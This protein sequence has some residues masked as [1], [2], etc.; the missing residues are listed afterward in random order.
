MDSES[1]PFSVHQMFS[2]GFSSFAFQSHLS[3]LIFFFTPCSPDSWDCTLM[4]TAFCDIRNESEDEYSELEEANGVWNK[5][6]T[7][8]VLFI[9]AIFYGGLVTFI[10]V[11][12][13]SI[14]SIEID[15]CH[16]FVSQLPVQ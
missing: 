2:I 15:Y 10:K 14:Q 7:F 12:R 5:V 1:V 6:F 3:N 9:L 8:I 4:G 11:K 13:K 16:L